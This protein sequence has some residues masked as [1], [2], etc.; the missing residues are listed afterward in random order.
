MTHAKRFKRPLML[1]ALGF[2]LG[3]AGTDLVGAAQPA[4]ND[5]MKIV[6]ADALF[7]IR[8][9]KLTTSLG[10]VDQFLTGISPFGVSMPIRAQLG[11]LLGAPEPAGVNMGGDFVIFG[12]L[13]GGE[14]PDLKRSA[15]LLPV[16]DF[17]QFLTNP[18]IVK[19]DAQGILK[20]SID[21]K[22]V[23]AGIQM[24][25][26]LLLTRTEDQQALGEA[27]N[28]TS[29]AGTASLAQRLSPDELKRAT[30][31][32]AWA[33]ANIQIVAKLYGSTIQ[34]KMKET[35]KKIQEAQPKGA[36]M[37]GAPQAAMDM[38]AS[39]LNSFMQE[40][41]FVSL[42]L[43]PSAAAIRLAPLVAA[44]PNSEM[45]KILSMSAT[46]QEQPTLM[47]YLENG[48]IMNGVARFSPAFS[49]AVG[50]KRV[51]L[52]TALLGPTVSQENLATLKKLA[53][54]SADA[55][56]GSAAWSMLSD[57]KTKPPFRFRYVFVLKDK[58]KFNDVLDQ[59]SKMMKEGTL[60]ADIGKK[61]GLKM[62]FD[63][64]RSAETYKDVPI[65]AIN[66]A[67]QLT[68]ANSP[69]GQ[70][71]K[72]MLAG[73]LNLRLAVVNDLLLY[74][75]AADP[76]KE[77]H[78]LIDQAKSGT[79]GQVPSEVQA[80]M[81]LIPDAKN[82][83]FFGTYNYARAFQWA[84]SFM[85]MPFPPVEVTSTSN[86]A[87]AGNVGNGS[88]LTNVTIPKQQVQEIMGII[89]KLQMQK[90]QEMQKQQQQ[91]GQPGE[92]QP[93]AAPRKPARKPGQT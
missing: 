60:L 70:M 18:N 79:P 40:T 65:D 82:A 30:S 14:K 80:A 7:C 69:Q 78:A 38:Y 37:V 23:V 91:P 73:G 54:D 35:A 39:L 71:M 51:D 52:L 68:D 87:F 75:L 43:D 10:Q 2:L 6:P 21:G 19:P 58:Q 83:A 24:G 13:P 85:P 31:S 22:P 62:Q 26:Y 56:S 41:Q 34:Q 9:N 57:A 77:I 88:L 45:A 25:S 32:P 42:S 44:V 15:V 92:Q 84:M 49:R 47:G 4:T 72:N 67:L 20:L 76:D 46:P 55:F 36:P 74:T 50:L 33:Y 64:K 29:G 53:T 61:F 28:W 66:I 86:V 48:A 1:L 3:A 90:M 8:I 27:K 11:K 81:Q 12:P 89:M 17:Q 16:S 63:L 5:P 93:P 59:A